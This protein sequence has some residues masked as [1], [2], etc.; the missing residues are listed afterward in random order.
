MALW[1]EGD[2][3]QVNRYIDDN[4]LGDNELFRQVLQAVTELSVNSERSLLETIGK[5]LN[6]RLAT[7]VSPKPDLFGDL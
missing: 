1:K 3:S 5:H 2:L 7:Y 6:S 4:S